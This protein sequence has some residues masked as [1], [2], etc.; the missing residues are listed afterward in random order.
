MEQEP[1]RNMTSDNPKTLVPSGGTVGYTPAEQQR[2]FPYSPAAPGYDPD[3]DEAPI[4]LSHYIW[5]LRRHKWQMLM[6]VSAVVLATIAI[7]MRLTP[8]YESTAVVD[9]DRRLPSA[10]LGD[11][12]N[13]SSLSDADQF[14]A[15]QINLIQAD[16]VLRPV[17]KK[18]KLDQPKP[19]EKPKVHKSAYAAEAPA[20]LDDLKVTRPPNTYLIEIRYRSEDPK[21]AADVSNA[22]AQSYIEHVY[23]TRIRA[24]TNM[25]AYMQKQLEELRAKMERSASALAAFERELNVIDPEQKTNILS[26]RLLQLNTEYTNA[27]ADR[28]QKEAAYKAVT[29]GNLDAAMVSSQGEQLRRLADVV[30]QAEQNFVSVKSQYG[31]NHPEYKRA[32]SQLTEAQRQF[33]NLRKEIGRRVQSEYQQAGDRES[34]LQRAVAQTKGEFDSLNARSFEYRNRKQE[35]EADKTLY[36]DLTKKIQEAGVNSAFQNSSIHVADPARP[37][38]DPVFPKT[39]LFTAIAFVLAVIISVGAVI[40]FDMLD[41]TIRDP[42]DV[43]RTM[44]TEVVGTLPAVKQW[45]PRALLSA[46][47]ADSGAVTNVVRSG[48]RDAAVFS[49]YEEAIRSLRNNILLSDFGQ[50][51]RSLMITSATPSEG[52]TTAGLHLA[53]AH[54]E[55]GHK[56]LLIDADLRRPSLHRY[57]NLKAEPLNGNGHHPLN[58][59]GS[60]KP[61]ANRSRE[62]G[63]SDVLLEGADWRSAV[64]PVP[65]TENLYILPAG[66]ASRRAVDFVGRT[67]PGILEQAYE[68]YDMVIMDVPPLLGFAEPLQLATSVDGVIVISLAGKT[69]R[70]AVASVLGTLNRLRA[71]VIGIVLNQ[72]TKDLGDNYYYYGYYGKGYSYR[73][74][75][76]E[77]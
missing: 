52:K 7:C 70:K 46:G 9:V 61:K 11:D 19:G 18:Y 4:P 60:P 41:S 62:L 33:D 35:A 43:V 17:V 8:I 51:L 65:E 77:A 22:I 37:A 68:D 30:N 73:Y 24:A 74:G 16:S 38:A 66:S 56:T 29:S 39:G 23:N 55:Q 49:D 20:E 6:F 21:L 40:L 45:R 15:T 48:K 72:V 25:S 27:Q 26:A 57:L 31:A 50:R 69:D 54:A 53:V 5:L 34:M 1:A 32:N 28:V 3:Q 76:P 2:P 63:L 42:E 67:I 59:E 71:N 14:L 13:Q 75:S 64:M 58:G 10:V 12:A 36:D 44:R 47:S